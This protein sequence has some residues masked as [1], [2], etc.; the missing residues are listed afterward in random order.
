MEKRAKKVKK[1]EN[2]K[3]QPSPYILFCGKHRKIIKTN[4]PNLSF[5]ETG[6][7]LSKIWSE[8]PDSEKLKYEQQNTITKTDTGSQINEIILLTEQINKLNEKRIN[9]L[10]KLSSS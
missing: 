2:P 4:N 9:L 7:L 3:R 8:L 5:G 1:E 10:K 6:K